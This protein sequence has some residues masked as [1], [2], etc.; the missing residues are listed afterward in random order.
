MLTSKRRRS[1]S[2]I[3]GEKTIPNKIQFIDRELRM[4][5][6]GGVEAG[7]RGSRRREMDRSEWTT[8]TALH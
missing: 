1:W 2:T 4:E 5:R 8:P 3:G 7:R 6:A